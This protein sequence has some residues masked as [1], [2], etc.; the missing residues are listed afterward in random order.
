MCR[1]KKAC[2]MLNFAQ[3]QRCKCGRPLLQN[4]PSDSATNILICW[5]VDFKLFWGGCWF[6]MKSFA[7][8]CKNIRCTSY[9]HK[10]YIG[11]FVKYC[12]CDIYNNNIIIIYFVAGATAILAVLSILVKLQI[13]CICSISCVLL[14]DRNWESGEL[15]AHSYRTCFQKSRLS[16]VSTWID[17]CYVL[18]FAHAPQ[19]LWCKIIADS[20]KVLWLRL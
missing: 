9:V 4:L 1:C 2:F 14:S 7:E 5:K 10:V 6:V 8:L 16:V 3:L 17:Y 13:I 18:G 19:F 11:V 15:V 20:S 12:E